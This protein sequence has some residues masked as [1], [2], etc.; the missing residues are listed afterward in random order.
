MIV[1]GEARL[2]DANADT[3]NVVTLNAELLSSDTGVFQD[4]FADSATFT[5]C[6]GCGP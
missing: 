1:S 4:L 3:L 2:G 5:S 6:T